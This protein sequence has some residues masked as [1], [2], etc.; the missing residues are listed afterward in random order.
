SAAAARA[1]LG[2]G[3]VL[4]VL[5]AS[6]QIAQAQWAGTTDISNTNSGNVGIGT[7]GPSTKLE[8]AGSIFMDSTSG[9]YALPKVD[10]S[11]RAVLFNGSVLGDNDYTYFG[12]LN[13]GFKF[14]NAANS[15]LVTIL[16]GGNVGIGTTAPL[17]KLHIKAAT[18]DNI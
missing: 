2:Y 11:A 17:A 18:N 3:F 15:P 8:V 13:N 12:S 7:T 1:I 5:F 16:N 6:A 9:Y 14:V 10:N 4:T